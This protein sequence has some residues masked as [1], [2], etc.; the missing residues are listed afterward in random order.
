M[1]A[2]SFSLRLCACVNYFLVKTQTA[3]CMLCYFKFALN[4]RVQTTLRAMNDFLPL[5]GVQ[6]TDVN[7]MCCMILVQI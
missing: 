2:F 6:T 3:A 1:T 5:G 4:A 7:L